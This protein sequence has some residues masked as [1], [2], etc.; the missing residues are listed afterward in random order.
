MLHKSKVSLQSVS[1][2]DEEFKPADFFHT[3]YRI[4]S[5]HNFVS[6]KGH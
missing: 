3:G 5:F 1:F 2:S 4:N 6:R